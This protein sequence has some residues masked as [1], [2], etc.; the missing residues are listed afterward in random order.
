MSA[1]A[2]QA[3]AAGAHFGHQALAGLAGFQALGYPSA[4]GL[5]EGQVVFL[6]QVKGYTALG[7]LLRYSQYKLVYGFAGQSANS[8][9]SE[10]PS[11]ATLFVYPFVRRCNWFNLPRHHECSHPS[12]SSHRPCLPHDDPTAAPVHPVSIRAVQLRFRQPFVQPQGSLLA[13]VAKLKIGPL[14]AVRLPHHRR[15]DPHILPLA[16]TLRLPVSS[17]LV[18]GNHRRRVRDRAARASLINPTGSPP[19]R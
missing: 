18:K 1:P 7:V 2:G 9:A 11:I 12:S 13:A 3:G 14:A 19:G 15:A 8:K 10:H 16:T 4:V 5:E 6:F 17:H